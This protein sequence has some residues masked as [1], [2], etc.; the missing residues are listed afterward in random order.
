[1]IK[2]ALIAGAAILGV[3]VSLP[4]QETSSSGQPES[5]TLNRASPGDMVKGRVALKRT[6]SFRTSNDAWHGSGPLTLLERR[7]FSFPG[8]FGW[9]E[10]TSI[11]FLPVLTAEALPRVTSAETL[12]GDPGA[13][14]VM[15][16]P[17]KFDYVGGEVGVF[18]GRSTGK[19]KRDVEQA[20]IFG[21]VIDGNTHIGVGAFYEH[22]NG[23]DT[24]I[25]GW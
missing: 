16:L 23:R 14:A 7:L 17:H 6:G 15:D 10:A 12:V 1:M 25:I 24:R 11:N 18:Y 22:S 21:E 2:R 19:S 8:A 13:K 4:A 3:C 20:Y 5:F 9:V